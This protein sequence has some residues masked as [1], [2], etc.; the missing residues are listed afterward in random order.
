MYLLTVGRRR[1]CRRRTL[2]A[3][4][5]GDWP[6]L[7]P[8]VRTHLTVTVQRCGAL[9]RGRAAATLCQRL[10]SMVRDPWGDGTLRR[11]LERQP[12]EEAAL[13]EFCCRETA[14]LL[15]LRLQTLCESRC[16]DLALAVVRQCVR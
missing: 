1:L 9:V 6:H 10:V 5:R 2:E 12:V 15:T 3:L 11:L 14:P 13:L 16:E 8:V 7:S 4:L